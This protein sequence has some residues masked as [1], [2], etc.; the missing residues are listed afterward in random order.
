[1]LFRS[2]GLDGDGP[3]CWPACPYGTS[4]DIESAQEHRQ[5][6]HHH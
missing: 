5:G 4:E 1:M 2:L 6:C 3:L